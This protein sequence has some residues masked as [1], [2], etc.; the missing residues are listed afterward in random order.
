MWLGSP[1]QNNLPT[2][3]SDDVVRSEIP[4]FQSKRSQAPGKAHSEVRANDCLWI[5]RQG[6]RSTHAYVVA[7]DAAWKVARRWF[8]GFLRRF[9]YPWSAT[10]KTL[11]TSL[12]YGH[13]VHDL[14]H[15]CLLKAHARKKQKGRPRDRLHTAAIDWPCSGRHYEVI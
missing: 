9:Q 12:Q 5:E 3:H 10:L 11:L 2:W 7:A 1:W 6:R 14:P 4:R 13:S 8:C 15:R